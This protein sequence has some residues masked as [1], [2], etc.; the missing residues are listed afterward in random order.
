MHKLKS[1]EFNTLNPRSKAQIIEILIQKIQQ[2]SKEELTH[3]GC[4]N[5]TD[6]IIKGTLINLKILTKDYN[7]IERI[8]KKI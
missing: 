4:T 6:R 2:L 3:T 7:E 5:N 8:F 1:S